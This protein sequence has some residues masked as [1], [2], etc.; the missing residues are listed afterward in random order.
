[1]FA[2]PSSFGIRG[3]RTLVFW[4]EFDLSRDWLW[5]EIG[6]AAPAG[7]SSAPAG[8]RSRGP[9]NRPRG[10]LR[11][12]PFSLTSLTRALPLVFI[13][14]YLAEQGFHFFTSPFQPSYVLLASSS[15]SLS[16]CVRNP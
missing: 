14:S 13:L 2:K 9:G 1:M 16:L 7:M 3:V 12:Q 11:L 5:A 10:F 15:L 8:F 6:L 4:T